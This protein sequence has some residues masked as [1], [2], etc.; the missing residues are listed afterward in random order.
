[1]SK[2]NEIL[3]SLPINF[4]QLFASK[5][6]LLYV[7]ELVFNILYIAPLLVGI[8]L[9]GKF[10][11]I[12]YLV[13]LLFFPIFPFASLGIGSL[14]SIPAMAIVKFFKNHSKT[15]AIVSIL[16]IAAVFIAYMLFI[17][18]ISGAFNIVDEQSASSVKI[19]ST[20]SK[21]GEKIPVF[22]WLSTIFFDI[23]T[24]WKLYVFF[25]AFVAIFAITFFLIK[26]FYQSVAV[27][28]N[29][30]KRETRAK[31][32]KFVKR[33]PE[34]ELFIN[35][36]RTCLRSP[37]LIIQYFLFTLLMPIIVYTYDKLLFSIAVSQTGQALIFA[38]HVLVLMM[39]TCL[40]STI[41]SVAISRQGGL[42]YISKMIP[43]SYEK[44]A[45]IKVA[46]NVLITW[47]AIVVTTVVCCIFS[48][49]N[50]I[51]LI[52]CSIAAMLV[53]VGH[54]CES[55]DIDLRSPSLNWYDISEISVL[56]KNTTRAIVAGFILAIIETILTVLGGGNIWLTAILLIVP[57][58]LFAYGRFRLLKI[59][60]KFV[61]ERMEM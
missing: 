17:T 28:N 18:K 29:E 56:S 31:A 43:V 42:L 23:K 33:S 15:T 16:F 36:F 5:L 52:I 32:K 6:V 24:L 61:F 8:G 21:I 48:T 57:S 19:N 40:S 54:V 9:I 10:A 39:L 38:S 51:L 35:E 41:S 59:R 47:I 55:Y 45:L 4:D 27:F 1:M 60:L 26:P 13:C 22:F 58:A 7:N 2:D 49:S 46:F 37:S 25:A 14:I 30:T 34:K 53:S 50:V 20:I 11:G 3:L 12:Y 44:Q